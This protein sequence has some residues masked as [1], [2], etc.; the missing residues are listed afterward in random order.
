MAGG[1]SRPGGITSSSTVPQKSTKP[2]HTIQSDDQRA[3]ASEVQA[4]TRP[5]PR[6]QV[7][8]RGSS[9]AMT[10][11]SRAVD[12]ALV[13]TNPLSGGEAVRSSVTGEDAASAGKNVPSWASERATC[14]VSS[15]KIS[16]ICSR[17]SP[18]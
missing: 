11:G 8:S 5:S 15:T 6:C 12:F 16:G 13:S 7:A 14:S 18:A 9:S 4:L 10:S 1:V 17:F 3:V 2:G